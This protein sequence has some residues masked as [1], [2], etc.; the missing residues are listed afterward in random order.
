MVQKEKPGLEKYLAHEFC[1]PMWQLGFTK[2]EVPP[3][4]NKRKEK[5]AQ[6]TVT[7]IEKPIEYA[8]GKPQRDGFPN[9]GNIK[10]N[11]LYL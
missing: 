6:I 8:T 9:V 10:Q 7:S 4:F 2:T 5:R 3:L 1:E 11:L